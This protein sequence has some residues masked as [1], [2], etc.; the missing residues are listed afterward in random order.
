M[1]FSDDLYDMLP[2]LFQTQ[3]DIER[4]LWSKHLKETIQNVSE[5]ECAA[6]TLLH[7]SATID[8]FVYLQNDCH[9][10]AFS[11]SNPTAVWPS[12]TT[13]DSL[14]IFEGKRKYK[15]HLMITSSKTIIQP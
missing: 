14:K 11:F 9:L 5:L 7:E 8:F 3:I 6:Y 1:Y 2:A 4:N 13:I 10:G 15:Y 12:D